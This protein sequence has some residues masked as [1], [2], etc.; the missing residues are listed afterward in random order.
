MHV[1]HYRYCCTS[2]P[3]WFSRHYFSLDCSMLRLKGS[4]N[5]LA[6]PSSTSVTCCTDGSRATGESTWNQWKGGSRS[7]KITRLLRKY[8][9]EQ[10]DYH[11]ADLHRRNIAQGGAN[12]P[13]IAHLRPYGSGCVGSPSFCPHLWSD[14]RTPA[15][16]RRRGPSS[17]H[18]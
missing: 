16:Q 18:R 10:G 14:S 11:R 7:R 13:I 5:T 2:N 6:K 3:C 9:G 15:S 8:E 17:W 1:A 4:D 12:R